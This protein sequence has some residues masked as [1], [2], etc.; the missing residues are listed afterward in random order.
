MDASFLRVESEA[1]HMHVGWISI[2]ELPPGETA[3][4]VGELMERIAGRLHLEPRF[5]QRVVGAPLGIGEAMWSDDPDFDLRRHVICADGM[6][7]RDTRE[8][9]RLAD[10]FLSEQLD[11]DRPLWS[12]LVV[13]RV[14][15]GRAAVIGKVHHA[16]VDGIAAVELGMVLFDL[17]PDAERPTTVDWDPD[18]ASSGL[19]PAIDSVADAAVDQFRAARR[20]AALGLSPGRAVRAADT[21]RRAAFSLAEDAIRAAPPSYLNVPISPERTV[22]SHRISMS[23][24]ARVKERHEVKLND[25]V[26]ALIAGTMRRFAI[27]RGDEPHDMRVMVPVSVRSAEEAGAGGNRITFAFLELP[28]SERDTRRQMDRIR[29]QSSELKDSGR[30]AGSDMLLRSVALLPE[31]LKERA[32]RLAAS[33]R[34]YNLT[35]S[36]VPGPT[37]PLYVAGARV[38]SIYPI[39]PIPDAHALSIG[40]LSYDG[41]LHFSAYAD[42]TALP[43]LARVRVML[44]DACVE[45][46][47]AAGVR[48]RPARERRPGRI[49]A[50]SM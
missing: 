39:V 20:T 41:Q 46:E 12:I 37:V 7:R 29:S 25:V 18:P 28:V 2:V 50:N 22:V 21:M 23:R 4:R 45:L 32:A 11:R 13:P 17:S 47:G 44:E 30:I 38:L 16:M 1:A 3:L 31:P 14:A 35:V 15:G 8:L 24:L 43:D 26:L 34:L 27:Q 9:R 49:R 36:N 42:P 40:V 5:R 33:P 48:A 6:R 19:R 10:D